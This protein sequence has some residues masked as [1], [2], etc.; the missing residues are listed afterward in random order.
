[1]IEFVAYLSAQERTQDLAHQALPGAPVRPDPVPSHRTSGFA[2]VR[3]RLSASL[4]GL[5]DRIEPAAPPRPSPVG[6]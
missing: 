6:C 2:A 1:M 4:R 3:T 5:A